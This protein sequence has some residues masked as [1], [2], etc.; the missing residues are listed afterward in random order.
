MARSGTLRNK[1]SVSS[2]PTSGFELVHRPAVRSRLANS[3]NSPTT[4]TPSTYGIGNDDRNSGAPT[5]DHECRKCTLRGA[6]VHLRVAAACHHY[7]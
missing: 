6:V 3:G 1:L 5:P 4:H 7:L 2:F